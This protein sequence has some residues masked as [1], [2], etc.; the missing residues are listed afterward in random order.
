MGRCRIKG[1]LSPMGRISGKLSGYPGGGGTPYEGPYEVTPMTVDQTLETA[2]KLMREDVT[3]Y[4]IPYAEV[5]NQYGIT[6]T[7]AS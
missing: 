4:E 1:R 7:I 2:N 3:I 5:A 6:A